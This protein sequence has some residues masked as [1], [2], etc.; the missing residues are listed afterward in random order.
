[1]KNKTLRFILLGLVVAGAALMY[2]NFGGNANQ[3]SLTGKFYGCHEATDINGNTD[4]Y[5]EFRSD[6]GSV[7]WDLT[8]YQMG[9][10]PKENTEYIFTYDNNG[11]TKANKPCDCAP[12]LECECEVYDDEFVCIRE[13]NK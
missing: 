5:Y 13:T 3:I 4:T 11:T 9:F 12:K 10:I 2:I 7:W 1:M 6:D 8:E